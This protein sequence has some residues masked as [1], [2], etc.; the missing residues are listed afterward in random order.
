MTP[1]LSIFKKASICIGAFFCLA[2]SALPSEHSPSDGIRF[3]AYN[4]KN[5]LTMNRYAG[6]KTTYTSKPEKEIKPLIQ[7]I[8]HA[9]PDVLGICEIGTMDDLKD[10]Q[11]R[12]QKAGLHLPH[13]HRTHGSDDTRALAILSRYPIIA[14]EKPTKSSYR[15]NGNTYAIK[16]GILDATIKFP[17]KT[18]RF[19]GVHLKSRR[20][21]RDEDQKLIRRY[22]SYL[23]RTHI[24]HILNA[25]PE[26][27]LLI[28]GDF[29][30]TKRTRTIRTIAGRSHSKNHVEMLD[31]AD[32]RGEKW[33]HHW[34][35]EDIYSRID[36]IFTSHALTPHINKKSSRILD[37]PFWESGSDHRPILVNIN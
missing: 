25:N 16:R 6:G 24:S 11:S 7:L 17:Q 23:L 37:L 22:E 12:L 5:Y 35:R 30:D 31:V 33:T 9:R 18:V 3:M 14:T 1:P 28:Y 13:I 20:P 10:F 15:L 26:T 36:F 34:A 2:V 4:L 21:S 32:S 27:K 29:N 19:L 8:I